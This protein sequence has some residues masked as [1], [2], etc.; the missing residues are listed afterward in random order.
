MTQISVTGEREIAT[1]LNIP[2]SL[3]FT[4]DGDV[5]VTERD[6]GRILRIAPDG[7]ATPLSGPGAQNLA[8]ANDSQGEAGLLGLALHPDDP[9]L[10]YVYQTRASGNSVL[11]MTLNGSSLSEPTAILEGIPKAR[12]HD[13]GRLAFGPDG[14]LYVSTGDAGNPDLAQDK[15]S[16]AGK[17]L[18]LIADGTDADGGAAPGNPFDSRV[19]TYG[20]RNV[21]GMA[22]VADGRM[23]ASEFGQS[24]LDEVNL[25]QAGH[26][27]GW[28]MVEA[29]EGAP[30]G[31][32][33]G[34]TVDGL[35]YP[36]VEWPTHEASPSGMAATNEGLYVSALRGER[37]W[38][39]PLTGEGVASPHVL[40]DGY[41]RIR[42]VAAGPDGG[43]YLL[44][45]NTDGRGDLREG[46]DRLVLLT[47]D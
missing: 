11:R 36:V 18:R 21:Q 47:L 15:D 28:P 40:I 41:G 5:L 19:W 6:A 39:I 45:G 17:I 44:T 12:N 38:R 8:S 34:Q 16:L 10:L 35:T 23:Y 46:D 20:H 31:T 26:N 24:S 13:G 27:Y 43:L 22:W 37:L 33:L 29:T 25:I 42:N 30:E 2:W 14:Y 7:T 32:Q 9:S 4:P 1:G 3:A